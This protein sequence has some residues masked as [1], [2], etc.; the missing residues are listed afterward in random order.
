MSLSKIHL[1]F[2]EWIFFYLLAF[3]L[4]SFNILIYQPESEKMIRQ[5][6]VGKKKEE[7]NGGNR[8]RKRKDRKLNWTQQN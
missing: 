1:S 8:K 3:D 5:H 6:E 2:R 4:K 7:K